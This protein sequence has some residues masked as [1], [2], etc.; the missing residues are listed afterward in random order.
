VRYFALTELLGRSKKSA[1]VAAARRDIER[2]APVLEILGRQNEDGGWRPPERLLHRYLGSVWQWLL[3]LELGMDAAHPRIRKAGR[4]ILDTIADRKTGAIISRNGMPG[5]P[6]YQGAVMRGLL[7]CG[8]DKDPRF[9]ALLR[10]I[11]RTMRFNDGNA[12]APDHDC[13]G[14]HT[15]VRGAVPVIEAFAE[16]PARF[17]TP[18]VARFRKAGNDFLLAH[19]IYRRSHDLSKTMNPYLTNLSFPNFYYPDLLQGLLVLTRQ[20]IRDERM[21]KAIE[22]LRRKQGEDG[23]WILQRAYHEKNPHA[24][25]PV[26]VSIEERGAPSKWITLRALTALKRWHELGR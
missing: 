11:L 16:L 4:F 26:I 22:A 1:E 19:H 24:R 6:C 3:L 7:R 25:F 17:V 15:C 5:G 21:K 20:G 2:S 13:Y 23:R 9:E 18:K 12:K 14:R 10:Y 8:L